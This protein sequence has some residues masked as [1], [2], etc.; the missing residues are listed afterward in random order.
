MCNSTNAC[1][2]VLACLLLLLLPAVCFSDFTVNNMLAEVGVSA[3][4]NSEGVGGHDTTHA[5]LSVSDGV[6]GTANFQLAEAVFDLTVEDDSAL[7]DYLLTYNSQVFVMTGGIGDAGALSNGIIVF[8]I[9]EEFEV[10]SHLG[11][12]VLN[13]SLG[14]PV[15]I[16]QDIPFLL[17]P[18]TFSLSFGSS[19]FINDGDPIHEIV[20][21]QTG[22]LSFD[23]TTVPEP[24]SASIFFMLF[25]CCT[26]RSR[27][28]RQSQSADLD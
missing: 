14:N 18:G 1:R 20:N 26:I 25:V 10:I 13:D 23:A 9:S 16:D 21:S 22:L 6:P 8:S 15:V 27:C 5:F 2:C 4:A 17:G 7:G 3:G 12:T 11:E 24:A 28:R 19:A